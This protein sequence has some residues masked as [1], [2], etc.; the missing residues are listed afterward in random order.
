MPHAPIVRQ[1]PTCLYTRHRLAA[2]LAD[3]H[4]AP[5]GLWRGYLR[6]HI[7]FKLLRSLEG[8]HSP[9][10]LMIAL[11]PA[12]R[13]GGSSRHDVLDRLI[14]SAACMLH[15][16]S[17]HWVGSQRVE[18]VCPRHVGLH[19]GEKMRR[20]IGAPDDRPPLRYHHQLIAAPVCLGSCSTDCTADHPGGEPPRSV[21]VLE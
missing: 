6:D 5:V 4:Y 9:R 8:S 3:P 14:L 7:F 11:A 20:A 17:A 2:L 1:W 21:S 15:S 13:C 16:T 10:V 18:E 12:V 19:V